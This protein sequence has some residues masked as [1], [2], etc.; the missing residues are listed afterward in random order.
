MNT[1]SADATA[2]PTRRRAA[3]AV[4]YAEPKLN[5]KLRQAE[6]SAKAPKAPKE[7]PKEAKAPKAAPV[8]KSI[9]AAKKRAKAEAADDTEAAAAKPEAAVAESAAAVPMAAI[10]PIANPEGLSEYELE[11]KARIERNE[12]FMA[13]LG[14]GGGLAAVDEGKR[15]AEPA[16]RVAEARE[17]GAERA[18]APEPARPG[19]RRRRRAAARELPRAAYAPQGAWESRPRNAEDVPLLADDEDDDAAAAETAAKRGAIVAALAAKEAKKPSARTPMD[20]RAYRALLQS[21]ALKEADVAK[22]T[23]DRTYSLA[24]LPSTDKLLIA[25]GDKSG[26]VGLWDVDDAD[27]ETC[28]AQFSDLHARPLTALAWRGAQLYSGGYDSF[29][30][31]T[32]FSEGSL[33]ST[34]CGGLSRHDVREPAGSKKFVADA[35]GKKVAHVACR[36]GRAEV[37]TS[38]NDGELKLWDVRK[39]GKKPTPLAVMGHD[40]SIHGFD[41]A[42]D[43]LTACSV[44]YD[45]TV[46]F[47]DLCKKVP[48]AVKVRHDNHTGRYLTPFKP[49]FD[50]HAPSPV[51]VVG[52]MAKPRAIDVVQAA[53]PHYLI[54]LNDGMGVFHAVTSIHAVHPFVHAIAGANNSGRVSL[55]RK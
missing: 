23:K 39:L 15:K 55:W 43:G 34:V 4:N 54:K 11:R 37:A 1:P 7:A 20:A 44:S 24:W 22:V 6:T 53:A 29:V 26:R 38:S 45:N 33:R 13:S 50:V 8:K 51:L 10:T 47:W 19:H 28:C 27:G 5:T 36:P 18:A 41:F 40:K 32:D 52:S 35:H 31:R 17:E 46:A 12:A 21:F 30:R 49:V 3:K 14:L 9:N 48:T 2:P 16:G 25:A 42:P